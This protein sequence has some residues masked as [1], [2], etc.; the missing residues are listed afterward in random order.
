MSVRIFKKDRV[1]VPKEGCCV[2]LE[3]SPFDLEIGCGGGLH[4]LRRAEVFKNRQIIAIEKTRARFKK[5]QNLLRNRRCPK[6]LWPLHTNAVWWLSHYGKQNMFERIFLLYPNPLPKKKQAKKRWVNRPFMSYLLSLLRPSGILEMR[7]NNSFY[8]M[9]FKEK[10]QVFEGMAL[11][12]DRIL[13][14]T[15]IPETD[16][17][18][19]YLERGD[20][21]YL[22]QAVKDPH[23]S[24]L[25]RS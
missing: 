9:E 1:P 24:L 7:T 2:P 21:C 14:K 22:L 4:A 10:I 20:R 25:K 6:N 17:E 13:N 5:F 19:K 3:L 16:F 8:Y 18:K 11:Q 12:T 15:H 23:N